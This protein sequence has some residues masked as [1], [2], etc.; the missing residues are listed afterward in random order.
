[1]FLLGVLIPT[2]AAA[3]FIMS[4]ASGTVLSLADA[5]R[6]WPILW[7]WLPVYVPLLHPIQC[8]IVV[9]GLPWPLRL[10]VCILVG[11]LSSTTTSTCS[12]STLLPTPH[13][14]P[15]CIACTSFPSLHC[16]CVLPLPI[17]FPHLCSCWR[18]ELVGG[19]DIEH[20][21]AVVGVRYGVVVDVVFHNYHCCDWSCTRSAIAVL[22]T[23]CYDCHCYCQ[24]AFPL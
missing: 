4:P 16:P 17:S 21:V 3:L 19:D 11:A 8:L 24:I 23:A 9:S 1:M 14:P 2:A 18:V 13:P 22:L 7:L 12:L 15:F 6:A 20:A 10:S 5:Q